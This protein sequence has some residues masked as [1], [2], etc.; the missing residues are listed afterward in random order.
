MAYLDDNH[1]ISKVGPFMYLVSVDKGIKREI[2]N[3]N[4]ENDFSISSDKI[5]FKLGNGE[6]RYMDISYEYYVGINHYFR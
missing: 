4:M 5:Y 6:I 2:L 1:M 3:A